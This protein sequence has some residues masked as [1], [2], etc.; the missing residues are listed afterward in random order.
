MIRWKCFANTGY[1]F[2]NLV[3]ELSAFSIHHL[4]EAAFSNCIFPISAIFHKTVQQLCKSCLISKCSPGSWSSKFQ[5]RAE[6]DYSFHK[7]LQATERLAQNQMP[8]NATMDCTLDKTEHVE[9]SLHISTNIYWVSVLCKI[10]GLMLIHRANND[11][12]V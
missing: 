9:N 6:C 11:L 8:K 2:P 10:T 4:L 3:W 5:L 7:R 12:K 1:V